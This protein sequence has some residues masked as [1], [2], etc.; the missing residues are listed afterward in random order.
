MIEE[1]DR[2]FRGFT[3]PDISQMQVKENSSSSLREI[4][5]LL[6]KTQPDQLRLIFRAELTK[7]AISQIVSFLYENDRKLFD[8]I[9]LFLQSIPARFEPVSGSF[10][11]AP[12]GSGPVISNPWDI[13]VIHPLF[14]FPPD[15]FS[16]RFLSLGENRFCLYLHLEDRRFF[17]IFGSSSIS[18]VRLSLSIG[19]NVVIQP[20]LPLSS[21]PIEI[22]SFL[23]DGNNNFC[24]STD[25]LDD[26]VAYIVMPLEHLTDLEIEID[27]MQRKPYLQGGECGFCPIS[28]SLVEIPV[29]G[30][31]CRHSDNF[32]LLS[33]V[34]SSELSHNWDCPICGR[35]VP[36]TELFL[37]GTAYNCLRAVMLSDPEAFLITD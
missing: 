3:M 7:P 6:D 19:M 28:H 4:K 27:I 15:G 1:L 16:P 9:L 20:Y 23:N 11:Q 33:Y 30:I 13:L 5:K 25:A 17:I 32:D 36:Y 2:I 12:F 22:T 18:S 21:F 8:L 14:R 10:R 26:P 34:S 31:E 24:I 35:P 29:R 37:D